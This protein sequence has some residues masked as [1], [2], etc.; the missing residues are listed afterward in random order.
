M[1]LLKITLI[2]LFL[3]T[4]CSQ[5]KETVTITIFM[6]LGE[7]LSDKIDNVNNLNLNLEDFNPNQLGKQTLTADNITFYE[8]TITDTTSPSVNQVKQISVY[9][10][11]T[12]TVA[13]YFE[14]FDYS[15]QPI[16][17][18]PTTLDSSIVQTSNQSITFK[19]ASGNITTIDV[20]VEILPIKP[21]EPTIPDNPDIPDGTGDTGYTNIQPATLRNDLFIL[22]NKYYQLPAD[23][24]PN[25]LVEVPT[26]LSNKFMYLTQD[27]LTAFIALANGASQAGHHITIESGFRTYQFQEQVYNSYLNI[28]P[29]HVVDTYSSRPGH[30]EHQLGTVVDICESTTACFGNFTGTASQQ[31][32]VENAHYYGFIL[33]YPADKVH[34]TKFMYESWHYRYVGVEVATQMVAE[35][36]TF[37]EYHNKYIK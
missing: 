23:Y 29:V 17:I 36:L 3:L 34:I 22:V 10:N 24:V 26:H 6:E 27:T 8:I 28:D 12:I 5:Q 7:S 9:Q 1:K 32:L 11:E 18:E 21:E 16:T 25:N 30:S 15:N 13:D 20:P 4:G 14:I 2:A 31:W 33:S 35:N 37:E 19:D